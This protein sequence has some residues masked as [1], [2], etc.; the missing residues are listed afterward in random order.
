MCLASRGDFFGLGGARSNRGRVRHIVTRR[1]IVITIRI[2]LRVLAGGAGNGD[3]GK[4]VEKVGSLL[5]NGLA[6]M[7]LWST[8]GAIMARQDARLG[9][10]HAASLGVYQC[11][12][13]GRE[14]CLSRRRVD[15]Q[16]DC[17][18]QQQG[19]NQVKDPSDKV[20]STKG[21]GTSRLTPRPKTDNVLDRAKDTNDDGH[22]E[23][24]DIGSKLVWAELLFIGDVEIEVAW[25]GG[26]SLFDVVYL[27]VE[28]TGEHPEL[29]IVDAA[30]EGLRDLLFRLVP[31]EVGDLVVVRDLGM[32]HFLVVVHD[33]GVRERGLL[34][35]VGGLFVFQGVCDGLG[36]AG[37][38]QGFGDGVDKG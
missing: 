31:A 32:A 29:L 3:T 33:E 7:V 10:L 18:R 12:R 25:D 13:C 15:D 37:E 23:T 11:Q 28:A 1:R 16:S 38:R 24:L 26:G 21:R 20:G 22:V 34:G 19:S 2:R 4:R 27:L 8:G 17:R 30:H 6:L 14:E 35:E 36:C 5:L 9:L